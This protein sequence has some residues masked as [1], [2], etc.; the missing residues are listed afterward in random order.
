MDT[1]DGRPVAMARYLIDTD[2]LIDLSKELEP[3]RSRIAA[4]LGAGEEV[5]LCPV[6][7]AEFYAGRRRGHRAD[8]DAF[9]DSLPCWVIDPESAIQAGHYRYSFARRGRT[10]Q[11]PDALTAA[12]AWRMR[13]TVI[14]RN[15]K[16]FPVPG[17]PRLVP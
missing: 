3:A 11:T 8:W 7:L 10:V 12:V 6:Q 16:D 1:I 15:G 17:V 5:G 9:V 13:A 4:L 14:T 2:V